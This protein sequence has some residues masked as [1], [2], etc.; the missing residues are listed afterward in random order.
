MGK[1][2]GWP[3]PYVFQVKQKSGEIWNVSKPNKIGRQAVRG[4]RNILNT[5]EWGL[6]DKE[7][8]MHSHSPPFSKK[9]NLT[10]Y[11]AIEEL[12]CYNSWPTNQR[13]PDTAALWPQIRKPL[14]V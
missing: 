7:K 3:L 4:Q 10:T 12:K 11:F 13:H 2:I 5:N 9:K 6:C 1:F 8:F 14:K